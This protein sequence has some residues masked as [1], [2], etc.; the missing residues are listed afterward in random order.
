MRAFILPSG[1]ESP[2]EVHDSLLRYEI[3]RFLLSFLQGGNLLKSLV[4]L[5]LP[6]VS[7][8]MKNYSSFQTQ[9]GARE[10]WVGLLL[11]SWLRSLG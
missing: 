10:L 8:N 7:I 2:T 3:A 4:S 9:I 1:G 5:E 6:G 11:E